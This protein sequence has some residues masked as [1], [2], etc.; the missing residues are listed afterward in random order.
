MTK[1]SWGE[2]LQDGSPRPTK[3]KVAIVGYAPSREETPFQLG[4]DEFEFWG[5]ND[6]W[7][8]FPH[9]QFDRWL[10]LHS[11]ELL[12]RSNRAG[13]RHGQ[14]LKAAGNSGIPVYTLKKQDWIKTSIKWPREKIEEHFKEYTDGEPYFT[15]TPAW[16]LAYAAMLGFEEIHIY[17][18]NLL[19]ED[20]YE[21][22]RPCLD[23]WIGVCRGL[24]KKVFIPKSSS[25][26]KTEYV[27]GYDTHGQQD[28]QMV[29]HLKKR[30][31]EQTQEHDNA[32]CKLHQTK[33]ALQ[34]LQYCVAM[35]EHDLRGGKIPGESTQDEISR[36]AQ[37]NFSQT[38]RG[39][40]AVRDGGVHAGGGGIFGGPG[41]SKVAPGQQEADPKAAR[42]GGKRKRSAKAA[43]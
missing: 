16:G 30:L 28:R 2:L 41:D 31:Q 24:G 3:N 38:V 29:K 5:M 10:D 37:G 20:E 43:N 21:Y 17:G 42:E 9:T 4:K 15:S 25:L 32:L 8:V 19:G 13:D 23:F 26:V 40:D 7:K 18:I 39:V 33:G 36:R 12:H 1:F 6:L 11:D 35:F 22:Q 34:T 14:W 27:Y